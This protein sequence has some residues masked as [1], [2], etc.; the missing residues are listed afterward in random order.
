MQGLTDRLLDHQH[1]AIKTILNKWAH[2]FPLIFE[3]AV[4]KEKDRILNIML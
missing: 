2:R 3:E 1:S 4:F